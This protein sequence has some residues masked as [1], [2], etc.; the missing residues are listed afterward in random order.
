MRLPALEYKNSYFYCHMGYFSP[1]HDN[2]WGET[3]YKDGGYLY[4]LWT[5]EGSDK[6]LECWRERITP[7]T[8]THQVL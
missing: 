5:K 1:S 8:P 6:I 3:D 7:P 2:P 4:V